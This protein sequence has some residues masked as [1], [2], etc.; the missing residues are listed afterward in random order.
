[1]FTSPVSAS[2]R[3][4]DRKLL[5]VT[6]PLLLIIFIM[7]MLSLASLSAI[8]SLRAFVNAE[9]L[10]SKAE[11][12]S[13]AELRRYSASHAEVDY[14]SF[15]TE[16][17]V[18]QSDR[19]AREALE[20]PHADTERARAGFLAARNDA[21][22]VPGMIRVF[23]LFH[24]FPLIEH[25]VQC[26]RR[27]DEL[28]VELAA[29]GEEM[30]ET[31]QVLDGDREVSPL[32]RRQVDA[33]SHARRHDTR[34]A[35][36]AAK[37]EQI[38][39]AVAPLED[40]FSASLG[41]ASRRLKG[42][43]FVLLSACAAG[44]GLAGTLI[45]RANLKRSERLEHAL[46]ASE[47]QAHFEQERAAV[48][49]GSISSAVIS[50][51][52]DRRITYMNA[53]AE[54]L[55]GWAQREARGED[56]GSVLKVRGE[57]AERGVLPQ[58]DRVLAGEPVAG[59][60]G[61]VMLE[62]REG[63]LVPV[64]ER[65]A[66]IRDQQ[67]VTSGVVLMLR[68]ITQERALASRLEYQATH[69]ALT[70]LRNRS[71]F[72]A[73]LA[74]AIEQ[75][76]RTGGDASLLYLD[77]DQFK[78]INDTCGHAAGDE[79]IRQVAWLVRGELRE[80]DLLARLGGDEFGV[81]LPGCTVEHA[82]EIADLIRRRIEELRFRWE[83]KLF[84]VNASIGVVALGAALP[85]VNAAMSAADHACYHA[86]DSGRNRITLYHPDDLQ[87]QNRHG[88]MRW[89][90]R[91]HAALD[92]DSFVLVAQEIH[93]I[94]AKRAP[95]PW[96]ERRFE[97]LLRM[98]DGDGQLIAPMAFI[99]AAERY[100]LMPR[101][102]RWVVSHACLELGALRSRGVALPICMI[103]LSGASVSDL[104]LA[105]HVQHCLEEN[106]L[107]AGSF[108]FE[109]TETAAIGNLASASQ[110]MARL[111]ALGCPIALDDFGSGMSSFSYLKA[112]PIDFLKIDGV[113][114]RNLTADPIDLA[115]VESIQRIARLMG[116]KTVAE[117]VED[118]A[119]LEALLRIG[120]DYGQGY[121]L[122]RPVLL[123]ALAYE[124]SRQAPRRMA[125]G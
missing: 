50:I 117:C 49:L 55:T 4:A 77:L 56:I 91:L 20:Q 90:E 23:R 92:E 104:G 31:V 80:G 118:E 79:L 68:D 98:V 73:R 57:G 25:A 22:D 11:R 35:V 24:H 1:L 46:R 17:S 120:V 97:L 75:Q 105:D 116:L 62:R 64:H 85:T 26:W 110:L 87:M 88:E 28:M 95:G 108:G 83:H 113:Y 15:L 48:T 18:P 59:A 9:G 103:N 60:P 41:E 16:L 54:W 30:H 27:G 32:A 2:T 82:C 99:P 36:L 61:G 34:L 10:W 13:I 101:I 89:V 86:K 43:L 37:A 33:D 125:A 121:H 123:S 12:Q 102:D 94:G 38:H 63:T 81:L 106:G 96:A 112:L 65:A 5:S 19:E 67:G 109:V 40:E 124:C 70:G 69:D 53:A 66:P 21:R 58:L 44:L 93:P 74:A 47:A 119:T 71:E 111:R 39:V 122:H 8:S 114:V 107:E 45:V 78:V 42:V 6:W 3:G 51:G 100:G 7:L 29:I 84:V 14:K 115:L 72:E 52:L 76:G